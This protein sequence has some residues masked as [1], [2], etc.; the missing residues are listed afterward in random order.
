MKKNLRL[1][2]QILFFSVIFILTQQGVT[3]T[4]NSDKEKTKSLDNIAVAAISDSED[5][6]VSDKTGRAPYFLIFDSNGNFI[7]SVKNPAQGKRGGA[8]SSVTNL[9]K[10]ESVKILIAGKFGDKMKNNL[11]AAKIDF[12][13][14]AGIAKEVIEKFIKN[15][16][17]KNDKE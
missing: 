12:Q 4:N 2:Y 9:L 3:G 14:Q 8:S 1:V 17:S 16:R 6:K 5:S 10:K 11:K 7:K 15:K 13:K